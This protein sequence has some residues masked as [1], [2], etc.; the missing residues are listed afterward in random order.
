MMEAPSG[1]G[2]GWPAP[3]AEEAEEEERAPMLWKEAR[4]R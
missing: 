2:P 3:C 4:Q 1:T